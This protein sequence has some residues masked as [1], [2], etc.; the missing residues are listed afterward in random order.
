MSMLM[1]DR[2]RSLKHLAAFILLFI[3]LLT[4]Q[5]VVLP[6]MRVFG[7][8]PDVCFAALILISCFCGMETGAVTGIAV[9]F[10]V[11]ALGSVGFSILP[12]CYL[13]CGYLFGY[14]GKA[15]CRRAFGGCLF[16]ALC[17]LPIRSLITL[18]LAWLHVG[19]LSLGPLLLKT[20]LP[21]LL[22]TALTLAI[23]AY[24]IYRLC[25]YLD[26]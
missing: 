15:H 13:L 22:A 8:V 11:D 19:E 6:Q 23:I 26:H 17:S 12:V 5:T 25:I 10:A 14:L 7:S 9:G 20:L 18:L 3:L 1:Q 16:L 24:P 2:R 21:E 4:A